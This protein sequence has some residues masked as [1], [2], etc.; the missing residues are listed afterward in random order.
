MTK[1]F[2]IF[3]KFRIIILSLF[4]I[5][6]F[7]GIFQLYDAHFKYHITA[8]F[9][10]S[11][12]LYKDM[13]V[14]Y[15]GCKIGH[16]Q[17]VKLSEDYKYTS[18][19]M[20]L[21]PAKPKLPKNVEASVKTHEIFKNYIDL[22]VE[23]TPSEILLVNGAII[24]G[25]PKVDIDAFLAEIADSGL[26]I[27]LIQNFSDAA[28]NLSKTSSEVKNFF[29]DSRLILKDNRQNLKQTT[30]DFAST[31][32]SLKTVTSRF[33]SSITTDKLK[34]TTSHIEKSAENIHAVTENIN[35]ATQNL[36]KTMAKID[37]TITEVHK[38]ASNTKV[39]TNGFCQILKKRFAGLR[40]FFGKPLDN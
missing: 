2:N 31:S 26:L 10:E 6:I 29:S 22:V 17:S 19:K 9:E 8:K 20:I 18:A 37:C 35:I 12:P 33:N 5:F 1:L 32:N 16:V 7:W 25:Q 21:Y 39:I 38:T 14:F 4:T 27:P 11:G 40:L 34:N 3:Y 28:V 30:K 24:E 36:D 23:D 15:K 13:P